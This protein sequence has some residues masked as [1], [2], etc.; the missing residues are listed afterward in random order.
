MGNRTGTLSTRD[1]FADGWALFREN[2]LIIFFF[3]AAIF[4]ADFLAALFL[5]T[6]K[7]S[8]RDP[9]GEAFDIFTLYNMIIAPLTPMQN[10]AIL[11]LE[12]LLQIVSGF[13]NL[14]GIAIVTARSLLM[15]NHSECSLNV[16]RKMLLPNAIRLLKVW[17]ALYLISIAP[18]YLAR[19]ASAY[20]QFL[21][22]NSN[23]SNPINNM[24]HA[25]TGFSILTNIAVAFV[26]FAVMQY[27]ICY[28]ISGNG[29]I[30]RD[31]FSLA[32]QTI[33]KIVLFYIFFEL[34]GFLISLPNLILR[35]IKPEDLMLTTANVYI[36]TI[37]GTAIM[38]FRVAIFVVLFFHASKE[39]TEGETEN[40]SFEDS[41]LENETVDSIGGIF[42]YRV[43]PSLRFESTGEFHSGLARV[44]KDTTFGM[45]KWGYADT[46]GSLVIPYQYKEAGDF[47]E[48]LAAVKKGR[49]KFY[50]DKTDEV[51]IDAGYDE[52]DMFRSGLAVAKIG[53]NEGFIDHDGDMQ[54]LPYDKIYG[55]RLLIN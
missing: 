50:I 49:Y 12:I 51:G 54:L 29:S 38:F 42:R 30:V 19:F 52:A 44:K 27:M 36:S 55:F 37:A 47:N 48:G 5:E 28:V 22:F 3:I 20:H 4:F 18:V 23:P 9:F 14:C 35:F 39:E 45:G 46:E 1:Y 6:V 16:V 7:Y 25:L 32:K 8:F 26:L 11:S 2:I 40:E 31:S 21:F 24:A 10:I 13:V 53:A 15:M 43:A 41:F 33:G 17:L 34:L